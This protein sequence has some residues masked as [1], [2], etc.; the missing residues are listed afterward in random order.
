M[1]APVPLRLRCP[2]DSPREADRH[3]AIDVRLPLPIGP[4]LSQLSQMRCHGGEELVIDTRATEAASADT[5]DRRSDAR[6]AALEHALRE[7]LS[8]A[9][10][11][12]ARWVVAMA[13][14]RHGA[15]V[16]RDH[17]RATGDEDRAEEYRTHAEDLDAA[18][19]LARTVIALHAIIEGR[20]AAPT[21]EELAAHDERGALWMVAHERGVM[22]AE[23]SQTVAT[24]HLAA[25]SEWHGW[26]AVRVGDGPYLAATEAMGDSAREAVARLAV[27]NG[28]AVREIL[29]PGEPTR[30]ELRAQ[31]EAYAAQLCAVRA[32]AWG[33]GAEAMREA[34]AAELV[35]RAAWAQYRTEHHTAPGDDPD[36]TAAQATALDAALGALR[37]LHVPP[38]PEV[39]RG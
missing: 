29:A 21:D 34:C 37:S 6:I 32:A 14:A 22:R 24:G 16:M 30:A 2:A 4:A 17:A 1:T 13:R 35:Q 15:S 19:T 27:G 5:E 39:S 38:C 26:R 10:E 3:L 11:G 25:L 31:V 33:E 18:A 36:D 23:V 28:L 7:V 8:T 12:G 9:P 20:S